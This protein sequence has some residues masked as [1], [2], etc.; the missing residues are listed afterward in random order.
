MNKKAAKKSKKTA[1]KSKTPRQHQTFKEAFVEKREMVWNKK[2]ARVKL[3]RS[4]KRSYRED[5]QRPLDLAQ[6]QPSYPR[7]LR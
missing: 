7:S 1:E 2:R 4:F 5:Y 3:H 6:A